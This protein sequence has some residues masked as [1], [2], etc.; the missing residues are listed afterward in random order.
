M[1]SGLLYR[2]SDGPEGRRDE[3]RVSA[4]TVEAV[5][6]NGKRADSLLWWEALSFLVFSFRGDVRLCFPCGVACHRFARR[7]MR[8]RAAVALES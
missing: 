4:P 2:C 6:P 1:I 3:V 5:E 8:F 7:A